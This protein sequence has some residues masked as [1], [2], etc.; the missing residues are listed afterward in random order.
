M[1]FKSYFASLADSIKHS[2]S[3]NQLAERISPE[4]LLKCT[5]IGILTVVFYIIYKIIRNLVSSSIEK[6]FGRHPSVIAG[7]AISYTFYISLAM[8][9]LSHFGINFKTI[10]GAAG[11]AGVAIGFAAQTSFSNLI[12]GLFIL[13]EKSLKIGDFISLGDIKGTIES[14]T[15]LSL[16]LRTPDNQLIRLPNSSVFSGTLTNFSKYSTRRMVFDIPVSYESDMEK[17]LEAAKKIPQRCQ[18]V[19]QDPAPLLWY[20]GFGD[21]VNLNIAVWFKSSDL[22][23]VQNEIYINTSKVF[24]EEGI[25]IPYTRYDVKIVKD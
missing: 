14:M 7:K 20:S 9:V 3:T 6:K 25:I 19:L 4:F 16:Q 22:F 13:G 15:I 18:S 21:A 17:A 12:S 10:W 11:V 23:N 1:N 5:V 8:F 24:K 2:I